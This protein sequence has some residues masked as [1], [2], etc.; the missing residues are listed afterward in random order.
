[1]SDFLSNFKKENYEETKN[2]K[3]NEKNDEGKRKR[4]T[5]HLEED[6]SPSEKKDAQASAK[7]EKAVEQDKTKSDKTKEQPAEVEGTE[8]GVIFVKSKRTKKKKKAQQP[9][10]QP[11]TQLQQETDEITETDPNYQKKKIKKYGLIGGISL[12]IAILLL[13]VYYQATHVAVPDFKGKDVIEARTWATEN[14][15]Q[16]KVEQKY[17]FEQETNTVISQNIQNKK[18]K[19]GNELLVETSL[20]ADPEELLVLPDFSPMKLSEAKDWISQHKAENLSLIEEYSDTIAAGDFIKLE[21]TNK[22]VKADAYKRKDKA[23]V[24]YSKGKETFEKDIAMLDFVGK[25]RAEIEDWAK[26]NEIKLTI[27]EE[28]SDKVESGNVISQSVSK[29]Q[30]VAK[31]DTIEVKISNGKA[32]IVP[33]FSQFK[34]EEAEGKGEG[35]EL[36]VKQVYSEVV[37]YGGFIFQTVEAGTQYAEKDAKPVIEVSYSI[38]KPYLKE[39]GPETLEGD[40]QRIF[41]EEYQSKGANIT[42]QI[43]Y[44]DSEATKG[45]VVSMSQYNEFVSINSVIQINISRGNKTKPTEN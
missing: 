25:T 2:Q 8:D 31:R 12:L 27:T 13:V 19:K 33:D 34:M 45:S 32:W 35:F 17:N 24:Y 29:D 23:K 3:L 14:G 28:N 4:R 26:K 36:R 10:T 21:I 40:L 9:K 38:G 16:L 6:P 39:L 41:Y 22:D 18:I 42:Y 15:V 11:Q 43:V 44:V 30:K 37:P 5:I 20:G 1:M 7:K